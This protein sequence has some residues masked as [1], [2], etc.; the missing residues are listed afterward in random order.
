M[1]AEKDARDGQDLVMARQRQSEQVRQNILM[2]EQTQRVATIP[3]RK[4][5]SFDWFNAYGFADCPSATTATKHIS[6]PASTGAAGATAAY[7]AATSAPTYSNS[8]IAPNTS[9][10]TSHPE[11]AINWR[12]FNNTKSIC[13]VVHSCKCS[14]T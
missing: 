2:R 4:Y 7:T 3:V 11:S 12:P 5:T 9:P 10:T 8:T 13:K 1:K 14:A 6:V